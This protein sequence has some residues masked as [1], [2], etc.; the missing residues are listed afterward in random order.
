MLAG[1]WMRAILTE[2]SAEVQ[3]VV[4]QQK[5]LRRCA[6]QLHVYETEISAAWGSRARQRLRYFSLFVRNFFKASMSHL[7]HQIAPFKLPPRSPG[8]LLPKLRRTSSFDSSK[9]GQQNA[10]DD[11]RQQHDF[12]LASLSTVRL[13]ASLNWSLCF[14]RSNL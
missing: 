3:E 12:F 10:Q 7:P 14:C 6:V 4:T 8:P 9:T 1:V 2:I 5:L 13:R 11:Q